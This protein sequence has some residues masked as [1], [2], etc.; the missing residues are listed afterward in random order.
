MRAQIAAG[1]R[2]AAIR[3]FQRLREI[4]RSD[5]GIGPEPATVAIY[6]EALTIDACYMPAV[7]LRGP[8]DSAPEAHRRVTAGRDSDQPR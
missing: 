7:V 8:A 2:Q 4:L 5:L 3:Q 6:E 1:N